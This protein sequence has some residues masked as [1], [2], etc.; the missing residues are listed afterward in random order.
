MA[1][2]SVNYTWG[3]T[4][5][6]PSEKETGTPH[7]S[8]HEICSERVLY[9]KIYNIM[10]SKSADIMWRLNVTSSHKTYSYKVYYVDLIRQK[11]VD[12]VYNPQPGIVSAIKGLTVILLPQYLYIGI[13]P[14]NQIEEQA[15]VETSHHHFG[16]KRYQP[17]Y[18]TSAPPEANPVP[19]DSW[20]DLFKSSSK[21]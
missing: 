3:I 16:K 7:P 5:Y 18:R 21:K 11:N 17:D 4:P 13:E 19:I 6:Q 9:E 12:I 20:T 8:L 10:I 14:L 2:K 15:H 1:T